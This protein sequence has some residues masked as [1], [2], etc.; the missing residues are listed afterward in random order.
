MQNLL[1]F[2]KRPYTEK[3]IFWGTCDMVLKLVVLSLWCYVTV[4]LIRLFIGS[5]LTDYNFARKFWW[6]SYCF[7]MFFGGSWLTYIVFFVRDYNG[8]D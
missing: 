3:G 1:T 5:L 6:F 8:D 4:I 7:W 2:L